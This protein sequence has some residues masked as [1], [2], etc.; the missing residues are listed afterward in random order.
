MRLFM[1]RRLFNIALLL[2]FLVSIASCDIFESEVS[3][4]SP[5][6]TYRN[7]PGVTEEEISVIESLKKSREKFF[8][9]QMPGEEAFILPDGT[10]AGFAAKLCALLSSLF[11]MEFALELRDLE[12]L[13]RGI[14]DKLLDF[15]SHLTP[16][17]EQVRLYYMT[18]PIANRSKVIF[19]VTGKNNIV[20]EKD[21]DGLR[22]GF[23]GGSIE[24]GRI[25]KYYPDLSFHIV[26]VDSFESAAKM[27]QAGEIDAFVSERVMAPLFDGY[28]FIQ[29]RDF[30]PLAYD[31]V[32]IATANPDLLPVITV[33][34]KFAAAGGIDKLLELYRESE[35]E[36]ARHI[37]HRSFTDEERRYLDNLAANNG[38]VKV[39][40]DRAN[41]PVSFFNNSAGTFQGIATDVLS[42]ISK[43]TD[44]KFEI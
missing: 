32:S 39:I 34:N 4:I 23:L 7:I 17:A 40:I 11:E 44:I 6:K 18:Q 37:L 31:P 15:T 14:D 29:S 3:G 1:Q 43:L 36:Y 9:G 33:I 12:A 20:T 8:Y 24:A 16:V 13:K 25:M 2:I 26:S 42:K 28:D 10:Y 5:I 21:V 41:Y 22:I 30:F 38:T 35:E 27:L 19:T